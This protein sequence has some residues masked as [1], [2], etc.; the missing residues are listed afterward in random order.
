MNGEAPWESP[1][2]LNNLIPYKVILT[3]ELLIQVAALRLAAL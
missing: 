2:K 3:W 1:H